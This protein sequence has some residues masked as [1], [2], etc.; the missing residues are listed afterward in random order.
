MGEVRDHVPHEAAPH[1]QTVDHWPMNKTAVWPMAECW[2]SSQIKRRVGVVT[3]QRPPP[4]LI[5]GLLPPVCG[6]AGA[7]KTW[8]STS[9]A[10]VKVKPGQQCSGGAALALHPRRRRSGSR[11]PPQPVVEARI[12]RD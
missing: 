2:L 5:V 4:L 7:V 3:V 10:V 12:T 11:A 9:G 1:V 8:W 6:P